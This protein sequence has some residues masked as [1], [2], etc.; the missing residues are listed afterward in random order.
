M[1]TIRERTTDWVSFR[2]KFL[3]PTME[4]MCYDIETLLGLIDEALAIDGNYAD[5]WAT[6]LSVWKE[7]AREVVG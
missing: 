4:A 3:H 5:D 7:K 2:D 1:S 6:A